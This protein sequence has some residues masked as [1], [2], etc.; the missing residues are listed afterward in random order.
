MTTISSFVN[1][2]TTPFTFNSLTRHSTSSTTERVIHPGDFRNSPMVMQTTIAT[3]FGLSL[4]SYGCIYKSFNVD[5][6]NGLSSFFDFD[7]GTMTI[8]GN[9]AFRNLD[10]KTGTIAVIKRTGKLIL[11]GTSAQLYLNAQELNEVEVLA[12]A[13][14]TDNDGFTVCSGGMKND[15]ELTLDSSKTYNICNPSGAGTYASADTNTVYVQYT[16]DYNFTGTLDNVVF[17]LNNGTRQNGA[18][19]KLGIMIAI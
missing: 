13:S 2:K 15:G 11:A 7:S 6:A 9:V 4:T 14:Y 16:G 1:A 17:V 12:G 3:P 5:I 10:A 18:N 8:Y 19:K